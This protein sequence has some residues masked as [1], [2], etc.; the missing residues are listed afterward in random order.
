MYIIT[1]LRKMEP[2]VHISSPDTSFH[3]WFENLSLKDIKPKHSSPIKELILRTPDKKITN[4]TYR[5]KSQQ[6]SKIRRT[7]SIRRIVVSPYFHHPTV[8][9]PN[10]GTMKIIVMP[11]RRNVIPLTSLLEDE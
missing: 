2:S 1:K 4:P 9:Y 6:G 5:L 11:Q 7:R 3:T 10:D 8:Q